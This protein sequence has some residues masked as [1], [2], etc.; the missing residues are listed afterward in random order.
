MKNTDFMGGNCGSSTFFF[1]L[2]GNIFCTTEKHMLVSF[3]WF[4][5]SLH[6]DFKKLP[7]NYFYADQTDNSK[8]I[9]ISPR[10]LFTNIYLSKVEE[11]RNKNPFYFW[12][13]TM[14]ILI[15]YSPIPIFTF[16]RFWSHLILNGLTWFSVNCC[17]MVDIP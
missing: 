12:N 4:C 3:I 16:R 1:L 15:V 2:T 5:R 17:F 11:F 6:K 10:T 14:V 13:F 8:K 9:A 7:K